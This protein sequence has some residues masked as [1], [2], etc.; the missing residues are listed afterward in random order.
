LSSGHSCEDFFAVE[1]VMMVK[2]RVL[3]I[4]L[5]GPVRRKTL[6]VKADAT[7]RE[8][9]EAAKAIGLGSELRSDKRVFLKDKPVD[10]DRGPN[11]TFHEGAE[12]VIVEEDEPAAAT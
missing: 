12:L 8:V 5:E 9:L 1:D 11:V 2:I 7:I 3:F 10:P 6:E 4:P